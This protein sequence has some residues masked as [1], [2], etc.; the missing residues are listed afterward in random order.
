VRSAKAPV[1]A[2]LLLGFRSTSADY[3]LVGLGG[4][5]RA[6]TMTRFTPSDGWRMIAGE[7]R[8]ENLIVDRIYELTVRVGGPRI[9][10]E[11][12]GIRVLEHVLEASLPY[13]QFGL[14][15]WGKDGGVEFIDASVR[16]E[17]RS[18]IAVVQTSIVMPEVEPIQPSQHDKEVI[19]LVH[20]IRTYARW[21][22]MLRTE[23]SRIGIPV[24]PTN[25]GYFDLFRFLLPV[26]WFR[27]AAVERVW[28]LVRVVRQDYPA[29]NISF[30]AHSF[31]TYIVAEILEKKFDFKAHRVVFC[32]SVIR[33]DFPFEQIKDR[34]TTIVNEVSSH[35]PWP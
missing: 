10:L 16:T 34:F 13:G 24:E 32:G 11:V 21:Q 30:I 23:F 26:P 7:G 31:G 2:R 29:S 18:G 27:K 9:V 17:E 25:Y 6:Y 8:V 5:D 12:D 14:F 22:N 4:Y 20:G 33:Y 19:I 15:S 3:F 35:D 1:D 28:D